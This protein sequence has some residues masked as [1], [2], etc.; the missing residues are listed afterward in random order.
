MYKNI[1]RGSATNL[2]SAVELQGRGELIWATLPQVI[3]NKFI[4]FPP[5]S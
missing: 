1:I 5:S 2:L 4:C 3:P